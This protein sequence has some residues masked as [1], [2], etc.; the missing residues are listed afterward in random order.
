MAEKFNGEEIISK[1]DFGTYTTPYT[2]TVVKTTKKVYATNCT[3]KRIDNFY[4]VKKYLEMH[5]DV[6]AIEMEN[7]IPGFIR[8]DR[9]TTYEEVAKIVNDFF[10]QDVEN[11]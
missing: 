1:S 11:E 8:V 5:P 9:N 7:F 4:G 3:G 6:E 2:F 10:K